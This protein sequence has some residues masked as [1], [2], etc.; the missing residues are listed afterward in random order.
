MRCSE[1]TRTADL[2][3]RVLG[4]AELDALARQTGFCLK[5]RKLTGIETV[6]VLVVGLASSGAK[7][8]SDFVR[9]FAQISGQRIAYK[10]F[11]DR[12]NAS[13][14]PEYLRRVYE[15][16]MSSL[17]TKP[18][19]P[20]HP[21][22]RHFKDIIAHDGTSFAVH[23]DLADHFPGCLTAVAPAAVEVHTTLSL[24]EGQVI[25]ATVS[26]HSTAEIHCAPDPESLQDRLLLIDA[27]YISFKYF[28]AIVSAGGDFICR[29]SLRANPRIVQCFRG[30]KGLVG[31]K[32]KDVSLPGTNVDLLV[33]STSYGGKK[34]QVRLVLYW[35]KEKEKHLLLLTSLDPREF[36][37]TDVSR[38]YRLRWQIEL[39][40]KE[41]KSYTRLQRFR[42]RS[43]HITEG[44][45]WG[46]LIAAYIRRFLVFAAFKGTSKEPSP[47]IGATLVW[48]FVHEVGM[49]ALRSDRRPFRGAV[50]KLL[51]FLRQAAE[52]TNPQRNDTVREFG[53]ARGA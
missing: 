12:L 50:G 46:S 2:L 51:E 21:K 17:V 34:H 47:L 15:M 13:A 16:L 42:T 32:L 18:P 7:T 40:F 45:I 20:S 1:D 10:P 25:A 29:N 22:L 14:F 38:L 4:R 37:P 19:M 24:L 41:C 33:E 26:P 35:V 6:W 44:L 5:R 53:L 11:H 31:H 9:I 27:G 48:S 43:P 23:R 39:F 52:R 49:S 30:P 8:L 3:R 36:S 28:D